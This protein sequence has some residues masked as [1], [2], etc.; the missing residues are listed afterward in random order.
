MIITKDTITMTREQYNKIRQLMQFA[1]WYIEE[2]EGGFGSKESIEQW[3]EDRDEVERGVNT[4][5][6]IDQ[7]IE[8]ANLLNELEHNK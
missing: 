3:E 2:H 8:H 5:R 1:Q 6:Y 4:I 7:E